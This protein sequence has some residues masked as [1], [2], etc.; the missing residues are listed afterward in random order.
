MLQ[1]A[2]KFELVCGVELAQAG[3]ELAAEHAAKNFHGQEKVV[4]CWN[5]AAVVRGQ[6]AGRNDAVDMGVMAPTPTI[7]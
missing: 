3:N 1:S 7:P 5:P 2:V 6:A 4:P